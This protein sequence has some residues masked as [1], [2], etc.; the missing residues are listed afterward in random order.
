MIPPKKQ[1]VVSINLVGLPWVHLRSEVPPQGQ[2][3]T[4]TWVSHHRKVSL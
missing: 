2:V 3:V 4:K 1:P